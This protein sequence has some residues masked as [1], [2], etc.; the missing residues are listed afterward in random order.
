VGSTLVWY[1]SHSTINGDYNWSAD[2]LLCIL[3]FFVDFIPKIVWKIGSKKYLTFR[4]YVN[5]LATPTI[6]TTRT[7]ILIRI[8]R[9]FPKALL[10]WP[11]FT[12]SSNRE[13]LFFF[14]QILPI[15]YVERYQS[16]LNNIF[17]STHFN[18]HC[19]ILI[20]MY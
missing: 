4:Q 13:K 14:S 15:N 3:A 20:N 7:W 17:I 12:N 18:S 11:F 16:F 19:E 6:H 2:S 1:S 10:S 9:I 5:Q 8:P